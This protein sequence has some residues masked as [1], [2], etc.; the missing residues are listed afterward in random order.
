MKRNVELYAMW[1]FKCNLFSV[2]FNN[3]L[4]DQ[5]VLLKIDIF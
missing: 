2:L 1:P 4:L 3:F 5:R